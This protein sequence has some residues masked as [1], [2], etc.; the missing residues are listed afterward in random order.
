MNLN[1]VMIAGNLTKDPEL[2]Y[3]PSGAPVVNIRLAVNR[4]YKT[5]SGEKK[6][7]TL[8][9][10]V[11]VWN[12][13]AENVAEYCAKGSPVFVEGRL[14]Q[15]DWETESGE[16]RY[17]IEVIAERVHFLR[18]SK[19]VDKKSSDEDEGDIAGDIEI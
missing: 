4:R 2:R 6:E 19:P 18:G 13:I 12:R 7:E 3:T 16:K 1:K 10:G 5:K 17:V 14:R 15:R 8:Y 9:I 11:V